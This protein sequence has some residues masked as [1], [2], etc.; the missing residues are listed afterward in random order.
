MRR[1]VYRS[2]G[3]S[4]SF[5]GV[6]GRFLL[7]VLIGFGLSLVVGL[8][9]GRAATMAVGAGAGLAAAAGAWL[10]T[11]YLQGRIDERDLMKFI[12]RSAL[13]SLYRV[14]PK[15]IRNLWKGFNLPTS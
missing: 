10:G 8:V 5:F 3:E 1:K 13:P 7:V 12:A 6:S 15:H 2:L 11:L 14:H 4:A 9:A